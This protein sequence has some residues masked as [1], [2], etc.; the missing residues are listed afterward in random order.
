MDFHL[1]PPPMYRRDK[2]YKLEF[3]PSVITSTFPIWGLQIIPKSCQN[4]YDT[5]HWKDNDI[6]DNNGK[7]TQKDKNKNNDND[8]DK[9]AKRPNIC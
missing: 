8:K 1:T 9:F 2:V 5:H 3:H 6:S 4:P 7:D